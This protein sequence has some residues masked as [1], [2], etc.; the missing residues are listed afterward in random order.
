MTRNS[1]HPALLR[2]GTALQIASV[3]TPA[4]PPGGLL[5]APSFVGV[6]GTDL[7]ILNG[8]RPDTAP[9]LGHEGGGFIVEAGEGAPLRA[10]ERIVFN[11]S[12][13]L[14]SGRILGHNFSG[15]YQQY[16][17]VDAQEVNDGLV[18]PMDGDLA[19]ICVALVEPLAGVIYSHELISRVVP[20]PQAAVVFGAGPIGLITAE[21]LR[22]HG[23]R[24]LLVH[25]SQARLSNAERL[26]FLDAHDAMVFTND[27][28]DRILAWNGGQRLDA[29]FICTSMAG[30]AGALQCA[31]EVLKNESCV[32]MVT[33]FPGSSSTPSGITADDLRS[34]R[35]ANLC[36][37]PP[38]GAYVHADVAGRRIAFTSHR[39]TSRDH[40]RQ[41]MAALRRE[42]QR[43]T[44]LVTHVLSLQEAADVIQTL[45]NVRGARIDGRDCIKAVVDLTL[46]PKSAV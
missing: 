3:P 41:S 19:A 42:G 11:P 20:A 28:A 36:G 33:N 4:A 25:S 30:A 37:V 32:E 31:V 1:H 18:Q 38:N 39:G 5:I 12:A 40:L 13:Q 24:A 21:Y 22:Q 7:A 46:L 44:A 45:S 35:Q 10:G 16:I 34:I 14:P 27:L 23:T 26:G 15:L 29:A 8:S 17:A 6:C 43:Y 2:R 9:I